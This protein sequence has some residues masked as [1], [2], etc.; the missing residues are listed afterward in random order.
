MP[1]F[2]FRMSQILDYRVSAA[3]P[4][5]LSFLKL[6]CRSWPTNIERLTYYCAHYLAEMSL[7]ESMLLAA[8][9]SLVATAAFVCA[10]NLTS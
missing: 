10:F 6:I 1:P 9:P 8:P 4:T 2:Y 3:N 7:M 5:V